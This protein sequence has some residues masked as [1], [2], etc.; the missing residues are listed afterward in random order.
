MVR[1]LPRASQGWSLFHGMERNGTELHTIIRNA[2]G[3]EQKC[4]G[5][6]VIVVA[7]DEASRKAW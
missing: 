2:D 4:D 1:V 7:M 6:R 3:T 5:V